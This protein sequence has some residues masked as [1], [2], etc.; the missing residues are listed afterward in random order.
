MRLYTFKD[1]QKDEPAKE[2]VEAV[3]VAAGDVVKC[4]VG[5]EDKKHTELNES[6][7]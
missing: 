6:F 1:T 3:A 7:V 4:E 5:A 2:K